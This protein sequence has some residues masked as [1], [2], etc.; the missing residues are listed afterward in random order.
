MA[1]K[2]KRRPTPAGRSGGVATTTSARRETTA[3]AIRPEPGT[4]GGPNRLA[5][6][7]EAR[8]QREAIRRRM[9]RRRFLG[10]A[11]VVALAVAVVA[12]VGAYVALKPNPAKAAECGSVQTVP[13]YDPASVD[14]AHVNSQ[15][16]VKTP[17]PLSTYRTQ[18]PTSGPHDL[19]PLGAGVYAAAPD[20]YR[21]IHSLE[22]GAVIVW[23]DPKAIGNAELRKIQS[24]YQQAANNDHVIVAPYDYSQEGGT[25][26]AGKKMVLVAWHHLQSCA[27]LNLAAAKDFIKSYR[28][29]VVNGVIDAGYR[30]D[31]PEAGS[32]I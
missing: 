23:F 11:G 10:R 7:E 17:P 22:H 15:G 13:P 12:G 5:R 32:A 8:R 6:K 30:G 26:P 28:V 25:L 21:T 27:N 2:K 14:R 29:L 24:F 9:A 31:A 1:K 20:I 19:N 3:P 4:P 18:P 16:V